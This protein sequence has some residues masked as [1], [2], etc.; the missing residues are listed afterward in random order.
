[1]VW[2][3]PDGSEVVAGSVIF[4][5]EEHCRQL[6][7]QLPGLPLVAADKTTVIGVVGRAWIEGQSIRIEGSVQ[8]TPFVRCFVAFGHGLCFETRYDEPVLIDVDKLAEPLEAPRGTPIRVFVLPHES[9][10]FAETWVKITDPRWVDLPC[11][12]EGSRL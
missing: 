10:G 3:L 2:K 9:A 7:E 1:M 12:S 6:V 5:E 11:I 8:D 4:T